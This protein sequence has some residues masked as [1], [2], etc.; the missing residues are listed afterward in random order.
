MKRDSWDEVSSWYDSLV[1]EKG[2][3]YHRNVVLPGVRKMLGD[4]KGKTLL[5]VACGQGVFCREA[6][7]LGA[8]VSGIDLSK[9]LI[10]SA[11]KQNPGN[12]IQ[13]SVLDAEEIRTLQNKFDRVVCLLAI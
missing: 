8:I 2:S 5:D 9:N 12:R 3:D 6:R 11:K 7:D 1:G 4:L 10:D 13:Y